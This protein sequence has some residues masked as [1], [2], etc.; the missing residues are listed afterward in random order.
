MLN[1][2]SHMDA[3]H[4][5]RCGF[6]LQAPNWKISFY[7]RQRAAASLLYEWNTHKGFF[8]FIKLNGCKGLNRVRLNDQSRPP[9]KPEACSALK[10]H[11]TGGAE[12]PPNHL[13]T[14]LPLKAVGYF[15]LPFTGSPV[16]GS[17]NSFILICSFTKS[18][19]IWFRMYSAIA[20]FLFPYCI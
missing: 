3:K 17:T 10:G 16:N 5:R 15:L 14:A 1:R 19:C 20:F 18:S 12:S 13:P 7:E 8:M 11:H 2:K 6:W 4:Y 9:A